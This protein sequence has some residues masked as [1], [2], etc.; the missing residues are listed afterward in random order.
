MIAL[1]HEYVNKKMISTVSKLLLLVSL[2]VVPSSLRAQPIEYKNDQGVLV[3]TSDSR[4]FVTVL[5]TEN[6]VDF[7]VSM[8]GELLAGSI[9]FT[10]AYDTNIL[11]LTDHTYLYDI[12]TASAHS[13]LGS[14]VIQLT[15][16][17]EANYPGFSTAA[18]VHLPLGVGGAPDMKTIV[19]QIGQT[20][21]F[22]KFFHPQAGEAVHLY[23]IYYRKLVPGTT[24]QSSHF[25]F[26]AQPPSTSAKAL[27][28]PSWMYLAM[29]IRYTPAFPGQ[30]V[31]LKPELF[32]FR[33]PSKIITQETTNIQSTMATLNA[34]FKR[35]DLLPSKNLIATQFEAV[36]D[37]VRLNWD[38]I[39]KYGFIYSKTDALISVKQFSDKLVIDGTSYDFPNNSEIAAKVFVRG[40]KTFYIKQLHNNTSPNQT[41]QFVENLTNL[42]IGTHYFAWPFIQYAF[43]T[44]NTFLNVG[45][46]ATFQTNDGCPPALA[47]EGGPYTVTSLAGLCW[48][49]NMAT[50]HYENGEPITFANAYYCPECPDSENLASTFGLLYTWYSAVGVTEG[51]PEDLP[52]L[53]SN[54]HVQGIC[55]E[56]WHVPS[57]AELNLL[58]QYSVNDLKSELY[59]LTPGNDIFGFNALPAGKYNGETDRF[60]DMY[61]FTGYWASDA[62]PIQYAHYFPITYYC[63]EI[64]NLTTTKTDGLSVRCVLD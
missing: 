24:L 45:E 7:Q 59:W 43:E 21:M 11:R 26:Y 4:M 41:V 27:A 30:Y 56:G 38:T 44:S 25:A 23:N 17:F 39:S 6:H 10:M 61:G 50:K 1:N 19:T 51:S 34:T 9:T 36:G 15:P 60:I 49:S 28:S 14:P 53:N 16:A 57:Q 29:N 37:T 2:L 31:L 52:Q 12:P 55:P 5:E 63:N 62:Q 13:A 20:A 35:G 64:K 8:I 46:K 33:S 42:S 54:G 47:Y 32:L 22:T 58:N 48:T 3:G 18:S 40:G